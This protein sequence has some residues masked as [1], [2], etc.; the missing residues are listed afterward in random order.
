MLSD[1]GLSNG[2]TVFPSSSKVMLVPIP[3]A[4]DEKSLS[5]GI[6]IFEVADI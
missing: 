4:T 6:F 3:L 5:L 2:S 1:S